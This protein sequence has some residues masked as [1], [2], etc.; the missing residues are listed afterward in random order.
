MQVSWI[1]LESTHLMHTP[2]RE[3]GPSFNAVAK[4]WSKVS[5]AERDSHFF[6]TLDFDDAMPVF[7]E[8][9]N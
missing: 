3:F 7:Q 5:S 9:R 2:C 8:V 6:A 1:Q 4:A